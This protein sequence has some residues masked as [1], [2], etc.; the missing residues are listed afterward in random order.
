LNEE[1]TVQGKIIAETKKAVR[2]Q[3]NSGQENWIAKSTITSIFTSQR[4]TFQPF[5]IQ[6]WVLEKNNILIEK[7]QVVKHII[8]KVKVYHSDNLISI[9]GIGSYFDNDLPNSWIKH[10]I[11][12]ILVVKSI[13]NIPKEKWNK[14]FFPEQIQGFDVYTGYNTLEMYQDKEN[15]KE[16]SGVNYKWASME[17]KYSE[18]STLLFGE[19]IRNKLPDITT[20]AFDYDDILARGIYHLEK[21]LKEA[22]KQKSDKEIEMREFSKGIFKICFY[23]C[24]YFLE[25]F[26]YT[27]LIKIENKLKEIVKIVSGIKEIEM[28]L[29]EA[30]HYRVK[31]HFKTELEPLRKD[32]I[33]FIIDLLKKGILHKKFDNSELNIYFT[34]YF[35]GFPHLKKK[36]KKNYA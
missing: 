7:E 22:Y 36:L 15:F 25:N 14:R 8:D 17:I 18:N 32:F 11:D 26:H 34:K 16:F 31:S 24:V 30:K 1:K 20:I 29:D 21:S 19:D 3:F 35:G 12:L 4:D 33:K 28:Y 2:I 9:Y 13:K 5:T 6:S 23:I 10:D 27:S